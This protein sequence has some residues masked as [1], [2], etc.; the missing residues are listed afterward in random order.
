MRP[1]AVPGIWFRRQH[2]ARCRLRLPQVDG[3]ETGLCAGRSRRAGRRAVL[4][5]SR[6]KR[7][8][9]SRP[10]DA[11]EG[12]SERAGEGMRCAV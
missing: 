6:R 3:H 12:A 4:V 10:E 5:R 8:L 9:A 11:R 1:A 7:A 2:Q